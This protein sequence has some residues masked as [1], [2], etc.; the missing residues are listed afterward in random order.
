MPLAAADGREVMSYFVFEMDLD[1][2]RSPGVVE[3][4]TKV[5]PPSLVACFDSGG[6]AIFLSGNVHLVL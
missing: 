3:T 6:L 5:I 4:K 2:K 1:M